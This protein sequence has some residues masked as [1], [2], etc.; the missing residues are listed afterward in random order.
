M[1]GGRCSLVRSLA[2]RSSLAASGRMGMFGGVSVR[3]CLCHSESV[4]TVITKLKRAVAI[5]A[6]S[7]VEPSDGALTHPIRDPSYPIKKLESHRNRRRFDE[8]QPSLR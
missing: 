6:V 1:E 3:G 7:C 5:A 2:W 4:V 8:H